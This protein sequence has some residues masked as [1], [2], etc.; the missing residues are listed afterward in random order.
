MRSQRQL[1]VGEALRH[2]LS[3]LFQRGDIPWPK[4]FVVP[5]ITISEV[6]MSPDLRNATVYF[7]AMGGEGGDA[8]QRVLSKIAGFFR[9]ELAHAVKLRYVPN[10]V[11][12]A[13][14]SLEYADNIER[15]L[16]DPIVSKDLEM[17]EN[18]SLD[19]EEDI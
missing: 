19:P 8:T 9:H 13:D 4:G 3:G 11:F 18:I 2:A 14:T 16:S 1:K 10:L 17:D 6:T 15:I 7:L 12:E 5:M